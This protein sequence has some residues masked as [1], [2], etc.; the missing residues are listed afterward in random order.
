[1]SFEN[2]FNQWLEYDSTASVIIPYYME[3]RHL[4]NVNNEIKRGLL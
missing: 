4:L 3:S 2:S 1:M